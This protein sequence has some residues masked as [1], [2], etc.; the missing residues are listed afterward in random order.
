MQLKKKELKVSR[1]FI[2][3]AGIVAYV[4]LTFFP[5]IL[6]I[7]YWSYTIYGREL[8]QQLLERL[9][10]KKLQKREVFHP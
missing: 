7:Q 6:A 5:S 9:Y 2:L 3:I 10:G 1:A 4:I 8:H